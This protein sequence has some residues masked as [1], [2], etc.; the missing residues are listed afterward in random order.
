MIHKKIILQALIGVLII[1]AVIY[2]LNPGQLESVFL[3]I[4]I[5][6]FILAMLTYTIM[7]VFMALRL[8]LI[9]NKVGRKI[10]L[11]E[12]ILAQF[13]GMLASDITP[14][15][16]GYLVTP[17]LIKDKVPV[18]SGFSA[19][20]GTQIID[21]FVKIL[22]SILAVVY[23][24]YA[25][26]LSN[27]L[28]YITVFGI[29]LVTAFALIM[30]FALWSKKAEKILIYLERI[31]LAGRI[32]KGLVDKI[33]TF[34]HEGRQVRSIYPQLIGLTAVT[35]GLKGVEWTLLGMA[36][37][38]GFPYYVYLL[39]QP[40][41]TILQFVPISPAGLGFQESGGLI[42]LLLLGITKE[43]AFVFNILARIVLIIPNLVGI[44]PI[45]KK[46]IDIFEV[47]EQL[48]E[49]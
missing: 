19:I 23:L 41:I 13:G 32:F 33:E 11:K 17:F 8:K 28:L 9:F 37:G 42:V 3:S 45:A 14:G 40:L 31:P 21:F 24:M 26:K 46:G 30:A 39:L 4:K 35:W 2:F 1:A 43:S 12:L 49:P 47:K 48:T 27:A 22:G 34:Q 6:Y 38:F 7:N 29:M 16:S 10:S 5:E 18:E 20:F 36:L 25:A 44:Y 15:R